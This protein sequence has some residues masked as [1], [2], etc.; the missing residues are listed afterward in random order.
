MEDKKILIVGGGLEGVRVASEK[1]QSGVQVTI[2]EK[3]PT[4]GAERIPTDRIITPD[5]AFENPEL[6]KFVMTRTL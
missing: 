2:I 6:D 1:V 5:N 4:L 3:F